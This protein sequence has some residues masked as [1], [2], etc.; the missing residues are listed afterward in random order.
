MLKNDQIY[1]VMA[2]NFPLQEF[3]CEFYESFQKNC[4]IE[5]L[6]LTPF[7]WFFNGYTRTTK[8]LWI[9]K[10]SQQF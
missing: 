4:V 3:S 9:I 1:F 8:V 5:H 7:G 6:R 10:L 2:K